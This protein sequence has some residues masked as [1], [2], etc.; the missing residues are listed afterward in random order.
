MNQP[1]LIDIAK[2]VKQRSVDGHNSDVTSE[3]TDLETT[4]NPFG[5]VMKGQWSCPGL[6]FNGI[7]IAVKFGDQK[8]I[9]PKLLIREAR[10]WQNIDPHENVLPFVGYINNEEG[11]GLVSPFA[12]DG[13][14]ST[15]TS[16]SQLISYSERYQLIKD[17]AEGLAHLHDAEI[18]HGSL[19]EDHVVIWNKRAAIADFGLARL[20]LQ[21]SFSRFSGN[22]EV[23]PSSVPL[24]SMSYLSIQPV[25]LRRYS[26]VPE[27]REHPAG[28]LTM[29]SD[30]YQLGVLAMNILR[31][32]TTLRKLVAFGGLPL[33]QL[34]GNCKMP[35]PD[36]RPDARE[37]ASAIANIK[38]PEDSK[39]V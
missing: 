20:I 32:N 25:N 16:G 28:D 22:D 38:F 24:G 14:L 19:N 7:K 12:E 13:I 1:S 4:A 15:L 35:T 10:I 33:L 27:L 34:F 18:V 30:V 23:S 36:E 37:V 6:P 21:Q 26:V 11:F 8:L 5:K 31:H 17:I 39:T 29:E 9:L 3:I 2:F